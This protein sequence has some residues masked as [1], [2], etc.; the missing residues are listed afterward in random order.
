MEI[1]EPKNENIPTM[2]ETKEMSERITQVF[3]G[4]SG[5]VAN[6]VKS[7]GHLMK[8][9]FMERRSKHQASKRGYRHKHNKN[10]RDTK[11]LRTNTALTNHQRVVLQRATKLGLTVDQYERIYQKGK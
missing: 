4:V 10:A 7:L 6:M 3:A 11:I 2:E 5:A 9:T 1:N 8:P